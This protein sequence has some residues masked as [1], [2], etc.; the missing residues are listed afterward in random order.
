GG[1]CRVARLVEH[2]VP[3]NSKT[4]PKKLTFACGDGSRRSFLLKGAEDVHLDERVM[5]LLTTIRE[6][7]ALAAK[8]GFAP[9]VSTYAVLP[10]SRSSGL[11]EW[12]P[13]TRPLIDLYRDATWSR[14]LTSAIAERQA[15]LT[16]N[17]EEP[18]KPEA[19]S[20][21]DAPRDMVERELAR[22]S[23]GG[24]DW[25][26]RRRTYAARLG[27][28]CVA[29]YALGLGDRHLENVL[30]DVRDGSVVDVDWGVCF[31][32][33]TRLRVPE[34]VPFRLTPA[35]R[36][37]LGPAGCA[38]GPFAAAARKTA[39]ALGGPAGAAVLELLEVVANDA[40]VEWR[41]TLGHG[42]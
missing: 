23:E 18:E 34:A 17:G 9:H 32:A 39:R 15:K 27:G 36:F 11:I 24:D 10:L 2:V 16:K 14:G 21:R 26:A 38:A 6:A 35:L 7:V 42:K 3:L 5:Q 33:G 29:N 40:R 4:R 22:W 37:P 20:K 12:V 41:A 8:G 30:L 19:S 1:F 25:C 13:Q 28:S 31:D